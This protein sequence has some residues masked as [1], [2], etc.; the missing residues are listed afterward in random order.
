MDVKHYVSSVERQPGC[1]CLLRATDDV[2]DRM[3]D[4]A[5]S[6]HG[7]RDNEAEYNALVTFNF[8]VITVNLVS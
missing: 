2:L 7:I 1:L 3:L 4:I 8:T 6:L 5:Q